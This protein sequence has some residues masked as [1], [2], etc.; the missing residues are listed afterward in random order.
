MNQY[1]KKLMNLFL[2]VILL[3]SCF[4]LSLK[5]DERIELPE[6]QIDEATLADGSFYLSAYNSQMEEG[7]VLHPEGRKR[8]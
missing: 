4:P 6:Q 7:G 2:S 5:A 1:M 3:I 8:R